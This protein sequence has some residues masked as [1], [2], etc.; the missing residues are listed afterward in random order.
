MKLFLFFET[1]K[2]MK[3]AYS[4]SLQAKKNIP[5]KKIPVIR[6]CLPHGHALTICLHRIVASVLTKIE[7]LPAK[8]CKILRGLCS[9]ISLMLL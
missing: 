3:I 8:T 2:V 1:R 9:L 5:P 4:I 6:I 7:V